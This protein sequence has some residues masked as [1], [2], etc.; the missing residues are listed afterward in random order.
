MYKQSRIYIVW[1]DWDQGCKE[2]LIISDEGDYDNL[3]YVIT[4]YDT[5]F[6]YV[7]LY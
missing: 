5:N 4:W 3:Q 1:E 6:I 2:L 7:I